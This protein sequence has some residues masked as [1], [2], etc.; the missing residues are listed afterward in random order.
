MSSQVDLYSSYE[1]FNARVLDAVRKATYGTDI[2]QNSWTTA[3][4]Y[5]HFLSWLGVGPDSHVLDVASGS[6]G[7]AIYTARKT[8][9]RVTGVDA[10]ESGVSNATKMAVG[11]RVEFQVADADA[12]L[13]FED[14][15]FDSL[16]CIDSMNHFMN[17]A[18]VLREWHR[19]L[20]RGGRAIFT[21][22]V[23]I[24]GPI[25]NQELA[26]R[27]SIGLFLFVPSGVNDKLIEQSGLRLLDQEDASDNATLVA[28]RWRHARANHRDELVQIEG[29]D[30]F[31]GLQEFFLAVQN[32]TRERRLSRIAYFV[33]K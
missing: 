28:G 26:T 23:V 32:L 33:E 31:E 21:D 5:D 20:R 27:A 19:V 22:P 15:T 17:R 4:E 30:R 18:L 9:C 12:R 25:T 6:G 2:G 24:T 14:D 29:E 8:G 11:E 16:L 3:D 7:P 1:D 10:S 13:P